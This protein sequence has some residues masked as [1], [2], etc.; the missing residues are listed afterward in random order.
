MAA[1]PTVTI[2][3]AGRVAIITG[4][5]AGIGEATARVFAGAGMRLALCA[6]RADRLERLAA[7]LRAK[8][9]E[10]AI[11]PIDVTDL[12]AVRRMVD[13]VAARCGTVDVLVNSAGRGLAARF[14]DTTPEEF[15]ALFEL[16]LVATVTA[17]QA[18]LPLMRRQG[19]GHILN[20][21]SVVGR[22]SLPGRAAYAATK[23]ALVAVSESLRLELR[24][25]D[26]HV[27]LVYPIYTLTEFH[28]VETRR[29]PLRRRGPVQTAE[30]VARAM[31]RC[32][33]HPRA[34]VYPYR[35]ARLLAGFA[36][37]F[38]GLLD[39]MMGRVLTR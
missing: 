29:F 16:N 23:F 34:E 12:S 32:V 26:I 36:A 19:R 38:P 11:Y 21:S 13:V 7:E 4:A 35:P 30:Q 15:R 27:S 5:S 1:R 9:S 20:V 37:V 39:R 6:R 8:G 10:V 17:S 3:T 2:E 28:D 25:S 14:E 33:R 18:V 24:G 31:L 22:R